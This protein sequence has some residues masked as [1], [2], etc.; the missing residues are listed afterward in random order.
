MADEP[1][2]ITYKEVKRAAATDAEA[3]EAWEKI[4][5]ITGAGKVPLN[6]DGD[7]SIDVTGISASKLERIDTLLGKAK[8]DDATID[9]SK[10]TKRGAK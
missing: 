9:E 5:E 4:G 3:R 7:A 8:T 1:K 10:S 2:A 6:M